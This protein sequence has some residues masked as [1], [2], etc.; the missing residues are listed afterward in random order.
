MLRAKL[1]ENFY[2]NIKECLIDL[3]HSVALLGNPNNPV[4]IPSNTP[5]STNSLKIASVNEKKPQN[6]KTPKPLSFE[7]ILF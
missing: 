7:K 4:T 6:P 2:S 3:R 1:K 5:S